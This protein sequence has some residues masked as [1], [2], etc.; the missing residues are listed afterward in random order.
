ME[1]IIGRE[2][3]RKSLL[4][5]YLNGAVLGGSLLLSAGCAGDSLPG[6]ASDTGGDTGLWPETAS[7]T[8]D[9]GEEPACDP[10]AYE[11]WAFASQ[12][13][14]YEEGAGAGFG[15]DLYPDVVFGPPEGAGE[16]A[17]SLD[18]LSLGENGEIVLGFS[19]GVIIDGPGPDLI[20]FENPFIG[21]AEPG[22]VSASQ[23]GVLWTEWSCEAGLAEEGYP[24][25][26]GFSP[27]LS[28]TG[29]CIDATDPAAAGG[30]A[31]DLAD[32]GLDSA[33]YVRIRDAGVS[34]PG[35]FDLD[36]VSIVNGRLD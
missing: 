32:L 22:V 12:V 33:A 29:N 8:G 11:P 19:G 36:A 3:R 24:G 13:I 20:V 31:F 10:P 15:Q 25:C 34:G 2:S 28:N 23:D 5:P 14:S 26:A 30:D 9:T 4:L 35:G 18:V 6:T 27:V 17:G 16:G 1:G 21:W 7:D